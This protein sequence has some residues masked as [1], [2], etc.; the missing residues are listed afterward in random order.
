MSFWSWKKLWILLFIVPF[1]T[2]CP[3]QPKLTLSAN[4]AARGSSVT[5][6]LEGMD[7][8]TAKV[9]VADL[10]AEVTDGKPNSVTFI[11]PLN[12][13]QGSQD[14]VI[15]SGDKVAR[16]KITIT[17]VSGTFTLDRKKAARGETVTATTTQIDLANA[18]LSVAGQTVTKEGV[19]NGTFTFKVPDNAPAGP[20]PVILKTREGDLSQTLGVLGDVVPNKLTIL[21]VPANADKLNAALDRLGF[22]LEQFRTLNGEGPCANALAD[23]DVNGTP[24]GQALEELEKEDVALQIDPRTSYGASSVDHLS[25]ISASIARN[26]GYTGAGSTIAILDTGVNEHSE[27]TGRLVFPFNAIDGST[28]VTDSFDDPNQPGTNEGHGTP[29]AVLAAG[30]LSG[31][32]SKASIMPV[33]TCNEKGECFSS[34]VIVGMCH[35]LTAAKDNLGN[36]ILNMSFGGDTPV[37]AL[38]AVMKY[39]LEK[40]VQIAAA[41]GNQGDPAQFTAPQLNAVHYPAAFKLDGLVA[42]GALEASTLQC[43]DLEAQSFNNSYDISGTFTDNGIKVSF[44]PFYFRVGVPATNG[45]ATISDRDPTDATNKDL[46]LGNLNAQFAFPYPLE[47]VSFFYRDVDSLVNL[48]VN[49]NA[50]NDN[51]RIV[52]ALSE[53]KGATLGGVTV[54]VTEVPEQTGVSGVVTLTGNIESFAVGGGSGQTGF[55]ID[56]I[57]PK[58]SGA[59]QP[60]VFSTRGSYVDLSAPGAAL[61]SGTP[62]GGYANAYEGTSFSTPLAAGA[63]ALWKQADATLT[64]AQIEANLRRDAIRLPFTAEEVGKGMLNLN[65]VPFTSPLTPPLRLVSSGQ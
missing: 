26:N 25:A 60:A 23:I 61:R 15:T 42:V 13:P 3:P 14:V 24:L 36:L 32:A 21:L 49:N 44:R 10:D 17:T 4:Q 55:F 9:K 52:N 20:Q 47:S 54:T 45:A 31:V 29:I 28:N 58:K 33:K 18:T 7:G 65:V 12:A 51:L 34:D 35:A 30:S 50:A 53:L 41:A 64:P 22:R 2:A 11:I 48:E 37:D 19:N 46:Y 59:W 39:A 57:C 16:G 38:E 63:M 56:D 6:S 1:L 27:L 40:G 62:G 8:T 5:A 43:V